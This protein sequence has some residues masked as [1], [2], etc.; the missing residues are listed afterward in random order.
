MYLEDAG[1]NGSEDGDFND[2]VAR[3]SLLGPGE[4][5]SGED[6]IHQN[7]P[8]F[9]RAEPVNT[10]TGNYVTSRLDFALPGRGLP[11]NFVR[12]YNS[13]RSAATGPLGPGW[14]HAYDAG[15]DVKPN[16]SAD[17]VTEGGAVIPYRNSAGTFSAPAG[18][19]SKLVAV[20]GGYQLT[21][22]DQVVYRFNV[23][24]SSQR[25]RIGT[26]TP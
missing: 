10:R 9:R 13:A 22:A 18:T 15:L 23:S 21:R 11:L 8:T 24:V 20:T 1:P 17:F 7:D 3:V 26:E 5:Y 6:T 2:L 4:R 12:T 19:R 16:G 14:T 25:S